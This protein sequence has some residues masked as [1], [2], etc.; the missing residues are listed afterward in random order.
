LDSS[1]VPKPAGGIDVRKLPLDPVDGFVLSRVDGRTSIRELSAVTGIPE[2]GVTKSIAK[3]HSLGAIVIEG[4]LPPPA[5]APSRPPSV[6]PAPPPRA[7]SPPPRAHDNTASSSGM[8][9]DLPPPAVDKAPAYDPRDLDEDVEIDMEHRKKILTIFARLADLDHFSIL[10]VA[11]D[12]DKKTIKRAYFALASEFHPDKFF[13]KKLGS[14]KTKMEA[15]FGR[16]TEAHDTLTDKVKRAEYEQYLKEVQ[17]TRGMEAMLAEAQEE[18][19]RLQDSIRR[20]MAPPAQAA[21]PAPYVPPPPRPPAPSANSLPPMDPQARRDALARR[22]M[23]AAAPS[24]APPPRAPSQP[25]QSPL[26][27]T[28]QEA[29]DALKRRYEERLGEAQKQQAKKYTA[30]GQQAHA[31]NDFIAAANAF[32]VALSFAPDDVKL[33]ELYEITQQKADTLLAESYQKQAAYEERFE[34][35]AEAAKS[36]VRVTKARPNDA[37]AHDRAAHTLWKA[38]TDLRQAAE[39]GKKATM[40]D[41]SNAQYKVTLATVYLAAGMLLNA[42]RELEQAQQLDPK[43]QQVKTLLQ[44]AQKAG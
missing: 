15:I 9:V 38:G 11:R 29:M 26:G 34:H 12:A 19:R 13:R 27:G 2:D 17:Q 1:R 35:W 44:Q 25:P 37:R 28:T 14:F 41:P 33:K 39:H 22:L 6:A 36:W 42:K 5:P 3:L 4:L 31:N 23:G 7:P 43:N 30:I 40:L 24:K 32:K 16:I 18:M 8:E 20:D 10:G 21:A